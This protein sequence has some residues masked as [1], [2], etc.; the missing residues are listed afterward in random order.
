VVEWNSDFEV[1][2]EPAAQT[3]D[4]VRGFLEAGLSSLEDRYS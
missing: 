2:A 3:V 4:L 1:T